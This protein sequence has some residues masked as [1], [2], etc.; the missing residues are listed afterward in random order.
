MVLTF[1]GLMKLIMALPGTTAKL[2]RTQI[3]TIIKRYFAGDASLIAEIEQNE[4]SSSP[5]AEAARESMED[6]P[7]VEDG[8]AKEA[9]GEDAGPDGQLVSKMQA[10]FMRRFDALQNE[11]AVLQNNRM[12]DEKTLANLMKKTQASEQR[13]KL[14][15]D[16][17]AHKRKL[18]E[19][20]YTSNIVINEKKEVTA[21]EI[22]QIQAQSQIQIDERL[23]IEAQIELLKLTRAVSEPPPSAPEAPTPLAKGVTILDVATK[24]NLLAKVDE[25]TYGE[26]ILGQAGK[27]VQKEP[28]LLVPFDTTASQESPDGRWIQVNQYHTGDEDKMIAAIK[29][30]VENHLMKNKN[31]PSTRKD[32]KMINSY[33]STGGSSAGDTSASY[34]TVVEGPGITIHINK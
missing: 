17:I 29:K 15:A 33:F 9:L 32:T 30:C 24:N 19:L 12:Q 6:V 20:E 25:R 5:L 18:D 28:Y 16:K 2:M 7:V 22:R 26:S 21:A 10:E 11:V 27:L 3:A 34:A 13:K 8:S 1:T 4:A 23:K 31:K 14:Y